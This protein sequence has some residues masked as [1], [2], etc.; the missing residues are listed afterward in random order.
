MTVLSIPAPWTVMAFILAQWPVFHPFVHTAVPAG[1]CTVSPSLAASIASQT[2]SGVKLA[3]VRVSAPTDLGSKPCVVTTRQPTNNNR[4][5]GFSIFIV[6]PLT[7]N[8]IPPGHPRAVCSIVRVYQGGLPWSN[9]WT[10]PLPSRQL[11]PPYA[12]HS[13]Q[14]HARSF[15]FNPAAS[16]VPARASGSIRRRPCWP[17]RTR[18]A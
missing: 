18:T 5:R 4:N 10:V 16:A 17:R 2:A 11:A 3:A 12:F 9:N 15:R 8:T 7:S 1:S 14:N 6:H 13:C